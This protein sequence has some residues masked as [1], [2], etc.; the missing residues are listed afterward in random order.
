MSG[1]P[2]RCENERRRALKNARQRR[3]GM[4]HK[5]KAARRRDALLK[6]YGIT[7]RQYDL[8]FALQDGK[9]VGC[10]RP[11]KTRRLAV[12]H[13]HKTKRVRGLACHNCNRH[14]IGKN[15]ADTA[16]WLVAYLSSDFDG[17]TL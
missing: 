11:P 13:D 1:L 10:G 3:Y 8:M 4:T 9:C 2:D 16:R 14:L 12:E 7:Q 17:R 6:K 5:G 15:T